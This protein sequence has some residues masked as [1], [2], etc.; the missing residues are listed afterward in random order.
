MELTREYLIQAYTND[1]KSTYQIA[2]EFHTYANKIRRLLKKWNIP[3]RDK[4]EAQAGALESGR[5]AHPT[6]GKKR[7]LEERIKIS[8]GMA[9]VWQRMSQA[10]KDKRIQVAKQNWEAMSDDEREQFRKLAC[11]AVRKA[12]ED[13]SKLEKHILQNLKISGYDVHF[14]REDVIPNK[15]MQLDLYI[16]KL[17]TVIEIDGP[18]H[19]YPIWGDENLA[20]HMI[21]DQL[22]TGIVISSGLVMIR[23]KNLMKDNSEIQKRR[24]LTK[25]LE[26]LK[27]IEAEF[28]KDESRLIEIEVK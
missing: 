16:P 26:S 3:L 4:S 23:I 12:A 2:D 9:K 17:R 10:E 5:H 25:L 8:E 22:K 13:G 18:A 24:L 19:F 15:K 7:K 28:P 27:S 1:K 20:K 14:H 21:S 6:K 11:E